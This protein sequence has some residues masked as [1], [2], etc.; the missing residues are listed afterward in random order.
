MAYKSEHRREKQRQCLARNNARR[1]SLGLPSYQEA[2]KSKTIADGRCPQCGKRDTGG[3]SCDTCVKK[4]KE[5]DRQYNSRNKESLKEKARIRYEDNREKRIA[6]VTAWQSGPGR[7]KR[8]GYIRSWRTRNPEKARVHAM[9]CKAIGCGKLIRQPCEVCG[10]S[11]SD[12]HHD[13]YSKPFDIRWLC[14]QHH[15]DLHKKLKDGFRRVT[16]LHPEL[17]PA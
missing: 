15:K 4:K 2:W 11:K 14:R 10:N 12:A 5:W 13:D 8:N 16:D 17:S 1:K 6:A 9:V 3:K 7:E